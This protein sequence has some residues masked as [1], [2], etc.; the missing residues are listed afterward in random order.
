MPA[1]FGGEEVSASLGSQQEMLVVPEMLEEAGG[2]WR[3][4]GAPPGGEQ[5]VSPQLQYPWL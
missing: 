1:G 2:C 3:S 4:L 5:G